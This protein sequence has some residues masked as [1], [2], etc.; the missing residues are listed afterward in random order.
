MPQSSI[1]DTLKL[2]KIEE[3]KEGDAKTGNPGRKKP[4]FKRSVA[5]NFDEGDGNIDLDKLQKNA[6]AEEGNK[7]EKE[8]E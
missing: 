3:H 1:S 5:M 4:K 7:G 2:P 6:E 8:E